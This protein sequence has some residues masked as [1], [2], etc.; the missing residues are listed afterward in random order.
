MLEQM[1]VNSVYSATSLESFMKRKV[2]TSDKVYYLKSQ[3]APTR[4]TNIAYTNEFQISARRA[5]DRLN[6]QK[7]PLIMTLGSSS[8]K[9]QLPGNIMHLVSELWLEKD[10]APNPDMNTARQGFVSYEPKKLMRLL[11]EYSF[12]NGIFTKKPL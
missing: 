5:L 8:E 2:E 6:E 11:Q 4:H 9:G 1:F 12:Y 10:Y 3:H 7:T